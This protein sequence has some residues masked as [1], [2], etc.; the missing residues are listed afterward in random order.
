MKTGFP[1]FNQEPAQVTNVVFPKDGKNPYFFADVFE[2]ERKN[3]RILVHGKHPEY[4]KSLRRGDGVKIKYGLNPKYRQEGRNGYP[5]TIQAIGVIRAPEYDRHPLME[6]GSDGKNHE[7]VIRG[8]VLKKGD[9]FLSRGKQRQNLILSTESKTPNVYTSITVAV[10]K[11]MADTID[12]NDI[13]ELKPF[14]RRDIVFQRDDAG[15]PVVLGKTQN[16]KS[17]YQY[18]T[19]ENGFAKT[20]VSGLELSTDHRRY[21]RNLSKGQFPFVAEDKTIDASFAEARQ[22][23]LDRPIRQTSQIQK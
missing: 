1:D 21:F 9:P 6:K 17:I 8:R 12:E 2:P 20:K 13:L 5:D 18:Q 4:V 15:R 7:K 19:D 14:I 11:D 22:E 3:V 23:S 10:P 16:G